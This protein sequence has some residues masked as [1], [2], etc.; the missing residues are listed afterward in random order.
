M[1]ILNEKQAD[2]RGL[3]DVVSSLSGRN[4]DNVVL[5]TLYDLINWHDNGIGFTDDLLAREGGH[6]RG[7]W[8]TCTCAI[9]SEVRKRAV[10]T[11]TRSADEIILE[12]HNERE[13]FRRNA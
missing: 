6:G 5:M 11:L 12:I 3:Q 1:N 9:S 8:R 2:D 13:S 7:S 4:N 10:L